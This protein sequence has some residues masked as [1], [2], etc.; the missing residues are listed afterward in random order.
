MAHVNENPEFTDLGFCTHCLNNESFFQI[1]FS[2]INPTFL[3]IKHPIFVNQLE[4]GY[5]VYKILMSL[6]I[7]HN[8][9]TMHDMKNMFHS[10]NNDTIV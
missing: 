4:F 7:A 6:K 8:R 3:N 1:Q 10:M 9:Q 5:I 2:N